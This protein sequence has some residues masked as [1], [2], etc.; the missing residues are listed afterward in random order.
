[1]LTAK[2]KISVREAV[3]Q[4]T[5]LDWWE[6]ALDFVRTNSKLLIGGVVAVVAIIAVVIILNARSAENEEMAGRLLQQA[7]VAYQQQQYKIAIEG[8]QQAGMA[9]LRSIVDQYSGTPS[10]SLAAL[11]LGNCYLYTDQFDKALE[12][13]DEA[14]FSSDV[15]TSAQLA[16]KAAAHEGKKE[17]AEAAKLYEK[18]AGL[19]DNDFL[20]ASR[21]FNAGRMYAM[22]G[23]K[24]SAKKMFDRVTAAETPRFDK[25]VERLMAQY[26]IE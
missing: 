6:D 5:S 23:D 12:A 7:Q 16:G 10:G 15:L 4:S 14:S 11:Y 2:K 19:D 3:P 18:A 9:G 17:Y 8:D 25:D 26:E 20:Q 22:A 13:F 21:C 24:E 1:V